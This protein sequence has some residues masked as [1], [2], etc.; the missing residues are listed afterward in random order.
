MTG[1][2]C[3]GAALCVTWGVI[4]G[5]GTLWGKDVKEVK[6]GTMVPDCRSLCLRFLISLPLLEPEKPLT[7]RTVS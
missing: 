5:G 7:T 6:I 2:G 1:E 4:L 3:L